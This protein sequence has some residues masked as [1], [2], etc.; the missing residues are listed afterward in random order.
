[1]GGED[2]LQRKRSGLRRTKVGRGRRKKKQV[3]ET[4]GSAIDIDENRNGWCPGSHEKKLS[5]W[6][7]LLLLQIFLCRN[8]QLRLV[9]KTR[10]IK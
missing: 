5:R 1:M 2:E 3:K 9:S 8:T 6:R 10:G 4:E 7:E